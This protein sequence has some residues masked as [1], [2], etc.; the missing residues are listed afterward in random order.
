M[1]LKHFDVLDYI[2]SACKQNDIL[3]INY[4]DYKLMIYDFEHKKDIDKRYL[5]GKKCILLYE[6][7]IICIDNEYGEVFTEAFSYRDADL[8]LKYLIEYTDMEELLEEINHRNKVLN[9]GEI[10]KMKIKEY[11]VQITETLQRKI[12]ILAD[13]EKEA[14]DIVQEMYD[15]EKIILDAD[16]H[17]NTEIEVL[18]I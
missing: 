8:A 17:E 10:K 14:H 13:N 11:T 5:C 15:N 7:E 1:K 6:K 2:L 16:D 4:N 3:I 9:T 18:W 12:T